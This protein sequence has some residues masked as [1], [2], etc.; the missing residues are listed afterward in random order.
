M[1]AGLTYARLGNGD[2]AHALFALL[3]PI[4]HALTSK[5]ADR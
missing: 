2:R 1:W 5:H 3:N 4:N